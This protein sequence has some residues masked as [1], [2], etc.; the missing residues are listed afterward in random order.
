MSGCALTYRDTISYHS[1]DYPLPVR[2]G[3]S[4]EPIHE[5]LMVYRFLLAPSVETHALVISEAG[6]KDRSILVHRWEENPANMVTELIIRDLDNSGLFDKTVDQL[7]NA[8]YRYALEGTIRNLQGIVANG[9][10]KALI[11]AEVALIDFETP[12]G[13]TKSVLKKTYRV[14]MP[15]VDTQPDSIVKALNAAVREL[16]ANLRRDI[17]AAL[18]G[19][20]GEV[21]GSDE[22]KIN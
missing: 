11:E 6:G 14:E 15:S 7:S 20:A 18:R 4:S 22:T 21:S 5:T 3:T 9:K 16:S 12:I 1:L 17:R 8:R 13:A 2:D 10:G 19:P